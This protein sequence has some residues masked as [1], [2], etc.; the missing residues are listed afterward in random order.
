VGGVLTACWI[1]LA[2]PWLMAF[3]L[4]AVEAEDELV[5]V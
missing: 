4:P 5:E 1:S 3:G 2:K